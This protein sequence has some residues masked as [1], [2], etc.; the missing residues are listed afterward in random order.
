MAWTLRPIGR[1]A[2]LRAVSVSL[3]THAACLNADEDCTAVDRASLETAARNELCERIIVV[4]SDL[5][6]L[7]GIGGPPRPVPV[8][9]TRNEILTDV[10]A[11][12]GAAEVVLLENPAL[13]EAIVTSGRGASTGS[14][15]ALKRLSVTLDEQLG[16]NPGSVATVSLNHGDLESL[17]IRCATE[18]CETRVNI[19]QFDAV[20]PIDIT[21]SGV[22]VVAVSISA[23]LDD[24]LF[25]RGLGVP[26]DVVSVIEHNNRP[27]LEEWF[28]F[29]RAEGFTGRF[30]ICDDSGRD[31]NNL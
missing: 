14:S 8:E 2:Y 5:A 13:R 6:S 27:V 18:V 3:L 1:A 20:R 21:L 11:V 16:A 23:P 7:D 28:A 26:S 17:E 4:N 25:L 29:L 30:T 24:W 12:V 22:T 15:P 10:S 31:C 19:T 9:I